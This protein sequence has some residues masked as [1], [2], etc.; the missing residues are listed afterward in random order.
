MDVRSPTR[1]NVVYHP[2]F[3]RT[4]RRRRRMKT[5]FKA[6]IVLLAFAAIV[7][8]SVALIALFTEGFYR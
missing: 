6:V 3:A 2:D 4:R 8:V 5:F 1:G 7:A